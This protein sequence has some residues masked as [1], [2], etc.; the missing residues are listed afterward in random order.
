MDIVCSCLGDCLSGCKCQRNSPT[1]H[2]NWTPRKL[3]WGFITVAILAGLVS[4]VQVL[5]K[6]IGLDI[7]GNKPDGSIKIGAVFG[8][9]VL[10]ALLFGV[11]SYAAERVGSSLY[12]SIKNRCTLRF[13]QSTESLNLQEEL[14]PYGLETT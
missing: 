5:H 2:N 7:G 1:E 12:K 14:T 13:F 9:S 6:A 3:G 4:G 11:G 10:N 8:Y